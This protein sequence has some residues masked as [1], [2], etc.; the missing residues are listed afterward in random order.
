MTFNAVHIFLTWTH[1][2]NAWINIIIWRQKKWWKLAFNLNGDGWSLNAGPSEIPQ[3]RPFVNSSTSKRPRYSSLLCTSCSEVPDELGYRWGCTNA[4]LFFFLFFVFSFL[5]MRETTSR[6]ANEVAG[7]SYWML[8][9]TS[10]LGPTTALHPL[11]GMQCA[12]GGTFCQ[13]FC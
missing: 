7:N 5:S 9:L 11:R 4:T 2:N 8:I 10:T 13:S 12:L 1:Y 6:V 3:R